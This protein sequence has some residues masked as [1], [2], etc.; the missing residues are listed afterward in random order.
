MMTNRGSEWRKWDLHIHSPYT[1]LNK[2]SC[3]DEEFISKI[4]EQNIL[5]IG[6]TNYFKFEEEEYLLKEKA[7]VEGLTVFLNLEFRLSYQNKE[8]DC[9]DIH[10]LFDNDLTNEN[11]KDFLTNLKL[12]LNGTEI[13]AKDISNYSDGFTKATVELDNLLSTL[14]DESLKLKNRYLIGFLSRGKGNSRTST[15][16]E[17]IAKKAHLIIHSSDS[18][19]NAETDRAFWLKHGKPMLQSSDAHELT[20]IGTKYTWI[21]SQ[22]TFDGFRQI[23]FEPQERVDI[24]TSKPDDKFGY[25]LIDYIQFN[26]SD[27]K[28]FSANKIY[29][30]PNLNTIIGGKSTGKSNLLRMIA[31]D[32]DIEEFKKDKH[33]IEW[34]AQDIKVQWQSGDDSEK[35]ILY[36]PQSYLIK[37][38][39]DG[40]RNI[41]DIIV[42]SLKGDSKRKLL[43]EN[44]ETEQNSIKISID[45]LLDRLFENGRIEKN[46]KDEIKNIGSKDGL[47]QEIIK[48]KDNKTSLL[49]ELKIE[50]KEI[51]DY[52]SKNEF[53]FKVLKS[54][55]NN[56]KDAEIL[57][58]KISHLEPKSFKPL[59]SDEDLINNIELKKKVNEEYKQI[60]S[61]AFDKVISSLKVQIELISEQSDSFNEQ[62]N[63]TKKALEPIQ[64]K[65]KQQ[66]LINEISTKIE[67][68]EKKLSQVEELQKEVDTKQSLSREIISEI[69]IE[70]DKYYSKKEN[71]IKEFSFD[72]DNL[73][74]GYKILFY[75]SSI[76]DWF[77]DNVVNNT[78]SYLSKVNSSLKEYKF[79][80]DYGKF[81]EQ[82][83]YLFKEALEEKIPFKGSFNKGTFVK[84][85]LGDW[86]SLEPIMEYDGD[87]IEQM[88][89][90]KKAFVLLKLLVNIDN[91]KYPILIDQPEDSL[92]NR[93]I[94]KEL[95]SYLK[96][97]KKQRQIIIVTHNAN[98]VVGA[99][100]ENIIVANQHGVSNE[101]QDCIQFDYINGALE[102]S[103]SFDKDEKIELRK[104]G[105]KEHVCEILEGGVD[106]FKKREQKYSIK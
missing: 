36:I 105:I 32:A 86:F 19:E 26:E 39:E 35:K 50:E 68:T 76:Y 61:D 43:Y 22:T 85:L 21:K 44:I 12:N 62:I 38:L 59:L 10:V 63:S 11:I 25:N 47:I 87:K 37:D 40:K 92:D 97:K 17:K 3:S 34:I 89:D 30:N 66:T 4:K 46:K 77:R 27:N 69:F 101:N 99:D 82:I 78:T 83:N 8:D 23:V 45:S 56:Q 5:V 53:I 94:Y 24:S 75:S 48:L 16:Y 93:S 1:H 58:G 13:K 20:K 64:L 51:S 72:E 28:I 29:L 9:C 103:K 6:L 60:I 57:R 15:N 96:V 79:S 70:F 2:Y 67:E 102:E 90:G 49:K 84:S 81:R 73:I 18:V 14:D 104:R 106:A 95:T 71:F 33:N 80:D 31:K 88:S 74:I 65:L 41:A 91:S 42:T 52:N 55:A 100:A 7:T 54:V 98:L